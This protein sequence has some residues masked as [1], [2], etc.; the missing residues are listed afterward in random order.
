MDVEH[1]KTQN[2]VGQAKACPTGLGFQ[3]GS[4]DRRFGS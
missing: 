3:V 2:P 4:D 1:Q